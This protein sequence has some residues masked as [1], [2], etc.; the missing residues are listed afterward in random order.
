MSDEK[1][2]DALLI[3]CDGVE[4]QIVTLRRELKKLQQPKETASHEE[5]IPKTIFSN[6]NWNDEIGQKL[7]PYQIAVDN[8]N[9]PQKWQHAFNILQANNAT[10]FNRFHKNAYK[11]SY[12][13]YTER[14]PYK[15]FRQKLKEASQ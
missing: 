6:L 10:I 13:L 9:D 7:G 3:F 4:A 12:W 15:I 1:I 5:A 11:D 8:Q 2:I 14:M